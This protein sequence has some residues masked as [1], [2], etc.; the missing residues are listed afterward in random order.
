MMMIVTLHVLSD[1]T[2]GTD[3]CRREE[4][5]IVVDFNI[6]YGKSTVAKTMKIAANMRT[7]KEDDLIF[8]NVYN[9][10]LHFVLQMG[11]YP[12][13][14]SAIACSLAAAVT[15]EAGYLEVMKRDKEFLTEYGMCGGTRF[16][17]LLMG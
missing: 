2:C 15:P 10:L 5:D 17:N 8:R 13:A 3:F 6:N 1:V 16:A 12:C 9:D 4:G 14:M 7:S 11:I